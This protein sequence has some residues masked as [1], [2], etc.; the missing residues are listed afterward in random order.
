MV[1][2]KITKPLE[3]IIAKA[4]TVVKLDVEFSGQPKP[5]V[6][7]YRNGKEITPE[8]K[9]KSIVTENFTTSLSIPEIA[10]SDIGKYEVRATNEAGEART[11]GT[12][13]VVGTCHTTLTQANVRSMCL[14][15]LQNLRSP[16]WKMSYP[17]SSLNN[18][19]LKLF[20]KDRLQF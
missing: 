11:S 1:A 4:S 8:T 14:S 17:P 5:E 15:M 20:L 9:G 2:P 18:L 10:R 6:K 19:N 13:A 16:R 7:W 3:A 12:V